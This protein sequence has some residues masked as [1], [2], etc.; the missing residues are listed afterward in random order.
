MYA[1]VYAETY[2]TNILNNM[3][4]ERKVYPFGRVERLS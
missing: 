1:Y 4:M 3:K 2:F